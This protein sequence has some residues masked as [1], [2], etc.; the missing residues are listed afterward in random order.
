MNKLLSTKNYIYFFTLIQMLVLV[1]PAMA[2]RY[3]TTKLLASDGSTDDQYGVAVA[4][5]GATGIVGVNGDSDNGTDSGSAYI[6]VRDGN[7]WA[8]QDKL[9]AFDGAA[10]DSFGFSVAISGDYAVVGAIGDDDKGERSGSAY[11]FYRSGNYWS[12]Q[13]K[14][15]APD[16]AAGDLFG[17]SVVI[18]GDYIL[19]GADEHDDPFSNAGAVYIFH[20]VGTTWSVQTKIM[21]NDAQEDDM[22]GTA[23][24]LSGQYALIGASNDDSR[25]GSAYIFYRS[26]TSWS[27]QA[28]LLAS[29][30]GAD[31]IFGRAV[32]ISGSVGVVGAPHYD[33]WGN[34]RGAAY[35]FRRSGTSWAE[36]TRLMAAD[37]VAYDYFGWSVSISGNN[38]VIGADGVDY[39]TDYGGAAYLFQYINSSWLERCQILPSDRSGGDFYGHSVGVSGD[40]AIAGSWGDSNLGT[41]SG[42]AYAYDNLS[43]LLFIDPDP[44]IG[45]Q[46]ATF[47]IEGGSAN[48]IAYLTYSLKGI[49][50]TF[51][52]QLNVTLNLNK[53][54]QAG[55][56]ITTNSLGNGQWILPIPNAVG[57]SVWFQAIQYGKKT[58]VITTAIQ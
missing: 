44:L 34:N 15:V 10:D 43:F 23:V 28:K 19:V 22:F 36:E 32:A 33:Y 5:S 55:G 6:V 50:S 14:L 56:V 38:I 21:A 48:T 57:V 53:P 27:Q 46:N 45:G 52:K 58:N 30:G 31:D 49:G 17:F 2:Q 7:A 29:D 24:S 8:E 25:S 20:R 4:I 51:V 54:S 26:G 39:Y 40:C 41:Y 18:D 11:V 35:V 1:I 9:L 37:G 42:S 12:Y 47:S 3:E 13:A 16:G